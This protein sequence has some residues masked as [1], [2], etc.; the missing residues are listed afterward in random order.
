MSQEIEQI[1]ADI[2]SAELAPIVD[3]VKKIAKYV[4]DNKKV[5]DGKVEDLE[6][7]VT[8]GLTDTKEMMEKGLHDVLDRIEDLSK[9]TSVFGRLSFEQDDASALKGAVPGRFLKNMNQYEQFTDPN[10]KSIYSDPR[11]IAAKH[12]WLNVASRVGLKEFDSTR[13]ENRAEMVKL[14]K[15]FSQISKADMGG[16]VDTSGGYAVPNIVGNEVFK[17]IRDASLIYGRSRQFQMTS[18]TLSFPDEATACTVGWHRTDGTAITV[19]EPVFGQKQLIANKLVGRA[20]FSLELLEDSNVAILPFLQSCFAEKMGADLDAQAIEGSGSPFTG[21]SIATSVN[22]GVVTTNGTIGQTLT[23][24]SVTGTF[25][26]LVR[27]YTKAAQGS[28]I[29]AGTWVCGPGV[30]AKIIGLVDNNGQPIVRLGTVEGQPNNTLFG[31][32]MIISSALV[33]V[34]LG[35]GTNSV[36]GLYYGQMNQLAFGTRQGFRWDVSE[37]VSFSTYQAQARMVG[38]FGYVVGVPTAWVRNLGIAVA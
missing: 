23:Y 9:R 36:G 15:V 13:E 28:V 20:I 38:R 2:Q 19:G 10:D 1:E 16:V 25:A 5:V 3:G 4:L 22:D 34:T 21:V 32:P 11:Y 7:T 27:I 8:R 18:D 30:Y 33:N 6:K 17:I 14:D 12:A 37:H 29:N 35:T 26:S 31:R 24:A